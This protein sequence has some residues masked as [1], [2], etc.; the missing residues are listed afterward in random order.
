MLARR[1]CKPDDRRTLSRISTWPKNNAKVRMGIC[2]TSAA[3][4][5][6]HL[7]DSIC[8]ALRS[9]LVLLCFDLS[10]LKK[11]QTISEPISLD[12]PFFSLGLLYLLLM[13]LPTEPKTLIKIISSF[14]AAFLPTAPSNGV[15][16]RQR[17]S[18]L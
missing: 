3:L 1:G 14:T 13:T 18:F 17:S 10:A 16:H 8:L 12:I 5:S 4:L 9:K 7:F 2:L 15:L 6:N 11:S